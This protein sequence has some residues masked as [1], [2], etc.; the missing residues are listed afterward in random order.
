MPL[1]R[2][3]PACTAAVLAACAAAPDAARTLPRAL[4][5]FADACTFLPT[6]FDSLSFDHVAADRSPAARPFL[7]ARVGS[8]FRPPKGVGAGAYRGVEVFDFGSAGL[9]ADLEG[10]HDPQ[11]AARAPTEHVLGSPVWHYRENEPMRYVPERWTARVDD[12]FYVTASERALL[13][14]A[15]SRAGRLDELLRPFDAAALIPDDSA[16]VVCT[17][18]RP[19]DA[20]YWS[21]PIPIEPVVACF[22]PAPLRLVLFHRT[23]LPAEYVMRDLSPAAAPTTSVQDTWRVTQYQLDE[24]S[25]SLLAELL[26]GLA[27]FI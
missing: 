12:R 11:P 17:L 20:S 1:R 19:D 26:F 21:R 16:T 14:R 22:R 18:P 10:F 6:G 23:A 7:C 3:L 13:V 2:S 5:P 24:V 27:I 15:L 25:A 9:P 8:D 4:V